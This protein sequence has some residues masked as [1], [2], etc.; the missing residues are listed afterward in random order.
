MVK[1]NVIE[2]AL[3]DAGIFL[4]EKEAAILDELKTVFVPVVEDDEAIKIASRKLS[5][6]AFDMID[7]V[8]KVMHE[9]A[10]MMTEEEAKN[11]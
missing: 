8:F 5:R 10:V 3:Y 7:P 1:V 6:E 11:F 9:C 2:V 4:N